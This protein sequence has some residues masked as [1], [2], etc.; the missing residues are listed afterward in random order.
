MFPT[1]P[2]KQRETAIL[3]SIPPSSSSASAGR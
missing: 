1:L 3:Q 2:R